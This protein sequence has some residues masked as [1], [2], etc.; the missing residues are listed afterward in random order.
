MSQQGCVVSNDAQKLGSL[1]LVVGRAP[2][3]IEA[4]SAHV[5]RMP[6]AHAT[7]W[8]CRYWDS[9]VAVCARDGAV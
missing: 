2:R 8:D 3:P 9:T 4:H 1:T 5:R 6:V 7:M